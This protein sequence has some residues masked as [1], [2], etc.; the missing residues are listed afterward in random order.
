MRE[1]VGEF[2]GTAI[3]I[4]LG[5][6]V[7]ANVLLGKTKGHGAGWI[8][9]AFG[10]GM[11]VY[12]GA[13]SSADLSGAHLNPAVTLSFAAAGKFPW[14]DAPKFI[15]AQSLGAFLGAVIV[16]VFYREHFKITNEPGL[17]SACFFT[18]PN[19]RDIPTAFFCEFVGTFLLLVPILL[20]IEPKFNLT[21][22]PDQHHEVKLG[23]GAI[24]SLPVGLLV[25][26]IGLSLGGTTGYA[27][28][29]ARD[30]APRVAHTLLPF[31][32]K[33]SNDWSYAW[34]PIVGPILGG[35]A[36]ALVVK[37]ISTL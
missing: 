13:F 26:A 33:D 7:V 28:N 27:I 29:P 36:A 9:I 17:K 15:V 20:M 25:L 5:N 12:V 4:I 23:L 34:V 19:I 31:T 21:L 10:W 11:A 30:V 24:G 37:A 22:A 18:A 2:L 16:Y 32:N 14:S 3:L 35:L 6:G 8:V 1:F